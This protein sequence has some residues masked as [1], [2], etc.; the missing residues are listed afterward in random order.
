MILSVIVAVAFAVS[1]VIA[2]KFLRVDIRTTGVFFAV[3]V[4]GGL[5][6]FSAFTIIPQLSSLS[7]N[8]LSPEKLLAVVPI[9]FAFE[10]LSG[11]YLASS[12]LGL[13]YLQALKLTLATLSL[14]IIV[15]S[16]LYGLAYLVV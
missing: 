7:L 10:L 8:L 14:T 15:S 5:A 9:I 6:L 3:N 2:A 1:L 13:R 11:T 4:T 16:A 12:I